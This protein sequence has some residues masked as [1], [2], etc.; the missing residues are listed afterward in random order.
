[1]AVVVPKAAYIMVE[2]GGGDSLIS[3][4]FIFGGCSS[5]LCGGVVG[6]RANRPSAGAGALLNR[7]RDKTW[8]FRSTA[9]NRSVQID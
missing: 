2:G 1:M 7:Q 9:E 3:L 5:R 4:C 8:E 6:R